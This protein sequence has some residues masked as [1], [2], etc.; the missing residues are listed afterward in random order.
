MKTRMGM[1]GARVHPHARPALVVQAR[2]AAGSSRWTALPLAQPSGDAHGVPPT[3]GYC[4]DLATCEF[5]S[6]RPV[7]QQAAT[8]VQGKWFGLTE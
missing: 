4:R 6:F 3:R 5:G 8:S 2:L 1:A 7:Q